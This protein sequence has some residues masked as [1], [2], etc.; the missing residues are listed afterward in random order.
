MLPY[1]SYP[2]YAPSPSPQ[3]SKDTTGAIDYESAGRVKDKAG[4][5]EYNPPHTPPSL[6]P[7]NQSKTN[8]CINEIISKIKDMMEEIKK[9]IPKEIKKAAKE[10]KKATKNIAK[11]AGKALSGSAGVATQIPEAMDT[12]KKVALTFTILNNI[13][14]M[15]DNINK[16]YSGE[17]SS[18]DTIEN[19]KK[20]E[21]KIHKAN[22]Y[23]N[24]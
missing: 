3:Q 23:I 20:L 5:L 13:N 7:K 8:E 22:K 24:E 14:L 18:I 1:S 9:T 12:G 4:E 11:G 17:Q 21:D 10:T 6:H 2:S 16:N 19:N 15:Y